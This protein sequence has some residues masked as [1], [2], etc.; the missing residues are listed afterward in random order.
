MIAQISVLI[1][2]YW[3]RIRDP[4]FND[5]M[6]GKAANLCIQSNFQGIT[7]TNYILKLCGLKSLSDIFVP[8]KQISVLSKYL[9]STLFEFYSKKWST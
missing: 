1:V 8:T 9:K 7:F 2:K 5:T 4:V 3:I 6:V